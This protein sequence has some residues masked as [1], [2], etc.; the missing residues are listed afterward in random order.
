MISEDEFI[1]PNSD[2]D[3]GL[4][5]ERSVEVSPV[6]STDTERN[7]ANEMTEP[8]AQII[9]KETT[10]VAGDS[11]MKNTSDF[12][13]LRDEVLGCIDADTLAL[14]R[15]PVCQDAVKRIHDLAV[16]TRKLAEMEFAIST[17]YTEIDAETL[18]T[19][20][21]DFEER[22]NEIARED[23]FS[24]KFI[25]FSSSHQ[26]D[27]LDM[28]YGDYFSMDAPSKE[29]W[30]ES[31]IDISWLH[32]GNSAS[33]A[34]ALEGASKLLADIEQTAENDNLGTRFQ[35][36]SSRVSMNGSGRSPLLQRYKLKAA[37]EGE[38]SG[39]D[40]AVRDTV[41]SKDP[42]LA[43]QLISEGHIACRSGSDPMVCEK[44][45]QSSD[46]LGLLF[47]A[48]LDQHY[49]EEDRARF[50]EAARRHFVEL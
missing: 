11:E 9:N 40:M 43:L 16:T 31:M 50:G 6:A 3:S 29:R 21:D 39:V 35:V 28:L 46:L 30:L 25:G 5:K 2:P 48:E 10:I 44:I 32:L 19:I 38:I 37:V 15:S 12:D 42:F 36:S 34:A 24:L 27:V 8:A 47:G 1:Q 49:S 22:T 14:R 26:K 7:K 20:I 17:L 13:R 33:R 45:K 4:V 18:R 23:I 41:A